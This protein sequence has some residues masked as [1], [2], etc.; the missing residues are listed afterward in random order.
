MVNLFQGLTKPKEPFFASTQG[1]TTYIATYINYPLKMN[2]NDQTL[3]TIRNQ[4]I[5]L[6]FIINSY[7]RY[8]QWKRKHIN[9]PIDCSRQCLISILARTKV[10]DNRMENQQSFTSLIVAFS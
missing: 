6:Q 5:G 7:K 9:K 4:F 3:K 8:Y 10:C 1:N 2:K